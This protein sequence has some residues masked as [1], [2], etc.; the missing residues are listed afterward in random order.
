[1]SCLWCLKVLLFVCSSLGFGT[2]LQYLCSPQS[3]ST[4][5]VLMV[6]RNVLL[7]RTCWLGAWGRGWDGTIR[8]E[9]IRP[10]SRWQFSDRETGSCPGTGHTLLVKEPFFLYPGPSW[11][12]RFPPHLSLRSFILPYCRMTAGRHA[13]AVWISP[14]MSSGLDPGT[15]NGLTQSKVSR[16]ISF[17]SLLQLTAALLCFFCKVRLDNVKGLWR[18]QRQGHRLDD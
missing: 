12:S 18:K 4:Y 13:D 5:S 8:L 6:W 9:V 7:G 15:V 10:G 16:Y 14:W 11:L 3:V 1:M 2:E 17:S